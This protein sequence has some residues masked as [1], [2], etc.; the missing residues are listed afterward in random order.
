MVK[1]LI[2]T[3]SLKVMRN[4][5]MQP[6]CINDLVLRKHLLKGSFNNKHILQKRRNNDWHSSVVCKKQVQG[7]QLVETARVCQIGKRK[8]QLVLVADLENK[9]QD[10][11]Q[12]LKEWGPQGSNAVFFSFLR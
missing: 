12:L 1:Y 2:K 6:H 7:Y 11:S 3:C 10:N 8:L 5:E 4:A 9:G